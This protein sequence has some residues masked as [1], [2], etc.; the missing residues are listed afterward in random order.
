MP[1]GTIYSAK[2]LA[3]AY[4]PLMLATI[5][6][7]GDGSV[8]RLSTDP[9]STGA[10]G[11]SY[12]GNAYQAR[13]DD[14]TIEIMQALS[15]SGIDR[16]PN[17]S[18]R[19]A[20]PDKS[21]W[22]TYEAGT[23]K[24]FKGATVKLTFV[25]WN[26]GQDDFSS[27]ALTRF[28][29]ICDPAR[30]DSKYL[31]L[32]AVSK[33]NMG[34]IFIPSVRFQKRCPW[35]F[36]A[37]SAQQAEAKDIYTSIFYPCG[38]SPSVGGKGTA[39]F[40]DCD[41][42]KA[43]CV[44]RGMY[45][46]DGSGGGRFGGIQFVPLDRFYGRS[47]TSGQF[48]EGFNNR[49]EGK[50]NDFVPLLYGEQWVDPKIMN[51]LGDGGNSTRMEMVLC[52]GEVED[53]TKVVVNDVELVPAIN[54]K[55]LTQLP[56]P[57]GKELIAW[58]LVNR[59]SR[60]GAP[61]L[62]KGYDGK[63]DPYGSMATI[64][65]VVPKTLAD[66]SSTPRVRVR[67]SGPKIPVFTDQTTYTLT[68]SPQNQN[69]VWI[70]IDVLRRAQW[71]YPEID[72]T[73]AIAA[74]N[75]CDVSIPFTDLNGNTSTHP[76]FSCSFVIE[77]KETAAEVIRSIRNSARLSLVPKDDK[78]QIFV[79]GTL[80]DQQSSAVPGSNNNTAITSVLA[81]GTS[82]NGYSAYDFSDSTILRL[83]NGESSLKIEQKPILDSP[84]AFAFTFQDREND[85]SPD[86]IRRVD[87]RDIALIEQEVESVFPVRG[88]QSFDQ[89]KRILATQDAE[90]NKGNPNNDTRGTWIAEWQ[91][92]FRAVHLRIGHIVRLTS[93]LYG[94]TNQ[95]FRIISIKP[96]KNFNTATIRAHWH[97]DAWYR[98]TYGQVADPEYSAPRR[99]L[100][101]R[102]AYAW[103]PY[104]A[105][106]PVG[107][108]IHGR[109]E[110][111]FSLGQ[112][113]EVLADKTLLGK[114]KIA[115][116]LPVNKFSSVVQPPF[117]PRNGTVATSGGSIVG[118]SNVFVAICAKD[119]D[120]L[121]SAPSKVVRVAVTSSGSAHTVSVAGIDGWDGPTAG[122]EVYASYS[123]D[124]L[125]LQASGSG[126]PSSV[127]LTSLNERTRGVPDI[128]FDQIYFKIKEVHHSGCWAAPA[129][130]VTS[131]SIEILGGNFQGNW[132]GY[133]MSLLSWAD[134]EDPVPIANFR[135]ASNTTGVNTVFTFTVGSPDPTALGIQ[136]G[137]I[138]VMRAKPT[139]G[140][141]ATGKYVEDPG[142]LNSL[143]PL[144]DETFY[145]SF[146]VNASPIEIQTTEDHNYTTGQRVFVYGVYGTTAANG[147]HV[148]TK[149]GP[150][151]FTL[152]GT[153]GNGDYEFGGATQRQ[154]SGLEDNESGHYL[155][156]FAGTGSG[157]SYPILQNDL[158]RIYIRGDWVITPDSTSRFIVEASDWSVELPTNSYDNGDPSTTA[159]WE[160]NVPNLNKKT[161][162]VQGL[163]VDGAGTAFELFAP[164]REIYMTGRKG[165]A[166]IGADGY[167]IVPIDADN[168]AQ[169]DLQNGLNQEIILLTGGSV[170]KSIT[171]ASN[172]TP[173]ELTVVGHGYPTGAHVTVRN[174][175][176]NVNANGSYAIVVTGADTFTLTGTVGAIGGG[177]GAYVAGTGEVVRDVFIK[178]PIFTGGTITSGM[179]LFFY[180]VQPNDGIGNQT[181][182]FESGYVGVPDS[183]DL[184]GTANTYSSFSFTSRPDGKFAMDFAF[185]SGMT[186]S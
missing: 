106:P 131:T 88:V 123:A 139:V 142:F 78:L 147:S 94:V 33:L 146:V 27:D 2:E 104:E 60:D 72:M 165:I 127:T 119:A 29:G 31:Y 39:G 180:I 41:F 167:A 98:D 175:E 144:V 69:P 109:T 84:N 76:R 181:I 143:G 150:N 63:G 129:G 86:S 120:G 113:Y 62:L 19:I 22:T 79:K 10:G 135:V 155:R 4:K 99:N 134:S 154:K 185:T 93:D 55:T 16:P 24:G 59:G 14:Q 87:A 49:N 183:P 3:V 112:R 37:T 58:Y 101:E 21:F 173:I 151:S 100:L 125:T 80:A 30:A 166:A 115:G 36:P 44:A 81:N 141:D 160:I 64:V 121:L 1:V 133:D 74:A 43:A 54:V 145:V 6:F 110:W 118:P 51:E 46:P 70:L 91:T 15:D 157:F 124:N 156:I 148:I 122:Y 92:T 35:S 132:A 90:T 186:R 26:V 136:T 38:Y 162:L 61:N 47:Y 45:S 174:V 65:A 32:S 25:F 130:A 117:V 176:G 75:Y 97:N 102:P 138:V 13:L 52:L 140:S 77:Q 5:T 68:G 153:T 114:V 172:A 34:R 152:D 171:G 103:Q 182:Q 169:P 89:A 179:N 159:S 108:S 126:T 67:V 137:D 163:A 107:D 149:T 23:G 177:N 57:K 95:P 50:Y 116:K 53:I 82:A 28:V 178:N 161:L 128:E 8:L 83:D 164:V 7:K 17:I 12:A 73:T 40:T 18:L 105:Q 56:L 184:I 158:T 96:D 42:T 66:T 85:Y 168:N 111:S 11:Y 20:D 48:E 9:L 170:R 71:S